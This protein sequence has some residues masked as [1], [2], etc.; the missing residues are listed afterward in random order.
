VDLKVCRRVFTSIDIMP[1]GM[2]TQ[3]CHD[4]FGFEK[5]IKEVPIATQWNSAEFDKARIDILNGKKDQWEF[6]KNCVFINATWHPE[7]VLDGHE[8]EILNRMGN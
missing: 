7:D 4:R 8:E 3:C 6:C 2:L 1:D 5:N